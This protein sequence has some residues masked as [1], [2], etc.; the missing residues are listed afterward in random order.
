[1]MSTKPI[2]Y[3]YNEGVKELPFFQ[4]TLHASRFTLQDRRGQSLVEVLVAIAIGAI[5]V[6]A[7]VTIIAPALRV[8]T[9]ASRVQIAASLAKELSDSVRVWAEGDWHSILDLATTSANTYY[10]IASSSPFTATSGVESVLVSTTTYSR[11]FYVEDVLRDS[12]GYIATSSGSNDPSTKQVTVGYHWP[13]GT[14]TTY[15]FYLTR[16]RNNVFRQTDWS[17]GSGQSGPATTTNSQFSTST[18]VILHA[19]TTGSLILNL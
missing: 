17:G 1:M 14:T 16:H 4:N 15:S 7:A 18:S 13:Q 5:L 11:Y 12:S 2:Q 19:S 9:Q 10:L 3:C 8:N 6:V